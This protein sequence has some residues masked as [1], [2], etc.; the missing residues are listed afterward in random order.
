VIFNS[1][2]FIILSSYQQ[3]KKGQVKN[4]MDFFVSFEV[5]FFEE[6]KNGFR[7]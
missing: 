3:K 4:K 5:F 1:F 2:D 7:K 6:K